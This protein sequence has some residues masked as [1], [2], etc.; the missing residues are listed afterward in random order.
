MDRGASIRIEIW[1]LFSSHS[2][3]TIVSD[4][5]TCQVLG[6]ASGLAKG[7]QVGMFTGTSSPRT[8]LST[9]TAW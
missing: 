2:L 5:G 9:T 3:E 6:I 8:P 4:A 1:W 7:H